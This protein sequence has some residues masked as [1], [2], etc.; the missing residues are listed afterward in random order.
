MSANSS[1]SSDSPG[2]EGATGGNGSNPIGIVRQLAIPISNNIEGPTDWPR[3]H[4]ITLARY[5]ERGDILLICRELTEMHGNG[6][7]RKIILW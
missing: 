2:P 7:Q 4:E 1:N 3:I 6:F 5:D